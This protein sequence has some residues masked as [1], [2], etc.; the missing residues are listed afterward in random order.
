MKDSLDSFAINK[1]GIYCNIFCHSFTP[2]EQASTRI[3][4]M[5]LMF[6]HLQQLYKRTQTYL[7]TVKLL[8]PL[9]QLHI[10]LCITFFF[11]FHLI[12]LVWCMFICDNIFSFESN[13]PNPS[14]CIYYL[15]MY[16]R[17]IT[18]FD[19]YFFSFFAVGT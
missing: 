1:G 13:H 14:R 8:G 10:F 3:N 12:S 16:N 15:C 11:F 18:E 6:V 17:F 9:S 19:A 7:W 4:A 2:I 5:L